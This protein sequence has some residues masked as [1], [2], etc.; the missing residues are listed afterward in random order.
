M[1]VRTGDMH[2]FSPE[3]AVVDQFVVSPIPTRDYAALALQ[4]AQDRYFRQWPEAR[5]ESRTL[6]W[7]IEI[8]TDEASK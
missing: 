3:E 2:D 5:K 6:I 4:K 1:D 8:K 7:H